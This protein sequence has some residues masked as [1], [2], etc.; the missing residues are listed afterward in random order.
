[1]G[2]LVSFGNAKNLSPL[3]Q[4][5]ENNLADPDNYFHDMADNH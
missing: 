5:S 1:M 2:L 3:I 4:Q